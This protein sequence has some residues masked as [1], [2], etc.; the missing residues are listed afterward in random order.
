MLTAR[1]LKAEL[2]PH[3]RTT[4]DWLPARL[5]EASEVWVTEDSV[6]MVHEAVTAG[7]R[8]GVLPVPALRRNG[9]VYGA[10]KHLESDGYAMT[11]ADWKA[12]DRKLPSPKP[13]NE[14][15]RCAEIVLE[16][17]FP[18]VTR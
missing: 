8:T 17:L 11:Y 5:L 12:A 7:A 15:A 3:M 9:R 13:L 16:R 18:G 2:M 14:T 6:S 10:I 4:P 1:N